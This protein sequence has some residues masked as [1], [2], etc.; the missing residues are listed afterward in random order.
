V[1]TPFEPTPF[2]QGLRDLGYVEGQNLVIELR[3]PEAKERYEILPTL[4]AELVRLR[5][6]VILADGTAAARAAKDAT[7]TIPIVFVRTADPVGFGLVPSLARPGGN[8]TGL[9]VQS[10][11]LMA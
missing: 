4:A 9:S 6:D 2:A 1:W 10:V 3:H 11:D 7:Q 5:P 8:I